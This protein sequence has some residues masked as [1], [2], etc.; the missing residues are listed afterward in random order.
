M[1]VG[2]NGEFKLNDP[3]QLA[4]QW[5]RRK[6]KP[7]LSTNLCNLQ[8]LLE[9]SAGEPSRLALEAEETGNDKE[10]AIN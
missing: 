7:G 9:N 5:G 3:E 10:Q 6:N 4:Q 2:E 8:I 1:W